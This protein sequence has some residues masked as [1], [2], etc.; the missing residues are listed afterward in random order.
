MHPEFSRFVIFFVIVLSQI[1]L[2]LQKKH[3]VMAGNIRKLSFRNPLLHRPPPLP[4]PPKTSVTDGQTDV[5]NLY[6]GCDMLGSYFYCIKVANCCRMFNKII[7]LILVFYIPPI[8][9]L[10]E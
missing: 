1:L 8:L 2:Q 6:I 4:P 7:V 9:L 3:N 5:V 10:E